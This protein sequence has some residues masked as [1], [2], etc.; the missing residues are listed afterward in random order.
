MTPVLAV[1]PTSTQAK[2]A[3]LLSG[4]GVGLFALTR[5]WTVSAGPAEPGPGV[6][7][8]LPGPMPQLA[9]FLCALA[10]VVLFWRL[11][12]RRIKNSGLDLHEARNRSA[13]ALWP[14][15]LLGLISCLELCSP[16]YSMTLVPLAIGREAWPITLLAAALW[17]GWQMRLAGITPG[18]AAKNQPVQ[19][20]R[21]TPWLV[22]I[23][24]LLACALFGL[25]LSQ[26]S[27][28][29]GRFMG[30]DEPQ[31]LFN[32]HTLAVDHD[33]D[34][35]NNV[36]LRENL[37][38]MDP[39]RVIGGH[40]TWSRGKKFISKHRPGLPLLTA[41]FYAW[42]LY[43]GIGARKA[44]VFCV[45]LL[46][47]WMCSEVFLLSRSLC[48]REP[49]ALAAALATAF[50]LPGVHYANLM[51]PEMAAAA[52]TIAAFRR[53][54]QAETDAWRLWLAAGCLSGYLAWFHE[55]FII[56]AVLLGCM[57]L[58]RGVW[59]NWRSLA[60]FFLPCLI[61]AGLLMRY[62]M[63]LYNR[64]FPTS[65]I[66][67]QG[68]YLN[69]RG[70]W[71]GL[72][73]LLFDAA[74]GL[75]PY[76]AV[77][78][79]GL[80]GLV[81]LVRRRPAAG[82]WACLLG[83]ATYVTAGLYAD[84]FGGINPPCRYLVALIPFLALGLAAGIQW[85]WP[86]LKFSGVLL[87]LLAYFSLMH[88]MLHPAGV[89]GHDIK[90]GVYFQFPLIENLLPSF[91]VGKSA[92]VNARIAL[93]WMLW[94]ALMVLLLQRGGRAFKPGKAALGLLAGL[95]LFMAAAIS[96][97]A[98]GP[99]LV[100]GRSTEQILR[101]WTRQ[102][103]MGPAVF[104]WQASGRAVKS[105]LDLS[106]VRYRHGKVLLMGDP[107][108]PPSG[109]KT[110]AEQ[111]AF[112]PIWG[113]YLTLPP[114]DYQVEVE[115]RSSLKGPVFV[116]GMDVAADQ[117]RQ[118]LAKTKISGDQANGTIRLPFKLRQTARQLECRLGVTGKADVSILAMRII[119]EP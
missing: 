92:A 93:V 6:V 40:A 34:L 98:M 76:A 8:H 105:G 7:W 44:A 115:L 84:W 22:F 68:S 5:L 38:F 99:G 9:A 52:F 64:P 59:R 31:Y 117:G 19:F 13:R 114:G 48:G 112:L 36:L 66:H 70:A 11:G 111:G 27:K 107:G 54:L 87:A 104:S 47:A 101:E 55:R 24:A 3:L 28:E 35:A 85:G 73:G 29:V 67:A 2:L 57:A 10:L 77:W 81:W 51:F 43:T 80:A 118:V 42:G 62:F 74:E 33:L 108:K 18:A 82:V 20:R 37:Y 61:S 4:L 15:A 39:W 88:V 116:A 71:E 65:S 56:L 103:R 86:N 49:P 25:R 102:D 63:A 75:L 17:S 72:S 113:Q 109:I 46:A 45:W 78:L 106:P 69:P 100:Q 79:L 60:A 94:A 14:L 91:I 110:M 95:A 32:A 50:F 23:L 58:W 26:A 53:I 30:G 12:E 21:W 16:L 41:P 96:A 119:R 83:L 89:Y 1:L 97:E 90:L